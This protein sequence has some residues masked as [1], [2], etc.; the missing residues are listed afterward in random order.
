MCH[1]S[2]AIV[3]RLLVV[4]WPISG[5]NSSIGFYTIIRA[6]SIIRLKVDELD[7]LAHYKGRL[8]KY[9]IHSREKKRVILKVQR[10]RYFLHYSILVASLRRELIT[11]RINLRSVLFH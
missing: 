9:Y 8:L 11:D 6:N 3:R 5:R 1:A 10:E 7:Y 4:A 2:A